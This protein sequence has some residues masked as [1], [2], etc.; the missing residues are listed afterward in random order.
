M[1][2]LNK[3][4]DIA[5]VV[6]MDGWVLQF[7]LTSRSHTVNTVH[8]KMGCPRRTVPVDAFKHFSK[9]PEDFPRLMQV[10]FLSL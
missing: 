3:T 10:P 6:P 2:R 5:V 1:C 9:V 8:C 7:R 4:D